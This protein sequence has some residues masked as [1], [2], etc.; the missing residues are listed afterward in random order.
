MPLADHEEWFEQTVLDHIM[1]KQS[2]NTININKGVIT[3]TTKE[4]ISRPLRP[5]IVSEPSFP[6]AHY[7]DICQKKYLRLAV[8]TCRW[9]GLDFVYK[10]LEFDEFT[11]AMQREITS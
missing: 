8:D 11:K 2:F 9:N 6:L 1:T 7:T 5:P 3:Y 10:Q 4:K